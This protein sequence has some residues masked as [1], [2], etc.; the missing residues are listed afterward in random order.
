MRTRT[1][2]A[3]ALA[4]L[5]PAAAEAC[6]EEPRDS[7]EQPWNV[8]MYVGFAWGGT[9][10]ELLAGADLRYGEATSAFARAEVR[11]AFSWMRRYRFMAGAQVVLDGGAAVEVGAAWTTAATRHPPPGWIP[12]PRALAE[13]SFGAFASASTWDPNVAL[14][15]TG[16]VPVSGEARNWDVSGAGF[17]V[18]PG[19]L[20]LGSGRA[21]RCGDLVVL[22]DGWLVAPDDE[23]R[24]AHV[25]TWA[26]N[27]RA[28]AASVPAFVRM[29]RELAILGAPDGLVRAARRAAD[30]EARHVEYACAIAGAPVGVLGLPAA[31]AAPRFA[32]A[33]PDAL[34]LIAREAWTDGVIGEGR[35]AAE[36]EALAARATGDDRDRLRAI[37]RDEAGHAALAADVLAWAATVA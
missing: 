30:E 24:A 7:Y 12:T 11:G 3:A 27:A 8:G 17:L 35:A 36:A 10:P 20:C 29:A 18:L 19:K 5:A 15:L 16:H 1:G 23:E 4:A 31:A 33:S 9:G 32:A 37:A 25:A 22:P 21:L 28:E 6:H 34:A 14:A 13:A 2:I 26:K